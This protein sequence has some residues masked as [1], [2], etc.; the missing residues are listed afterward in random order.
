MDRDVFI[1]LA[2]EIRPYLQPGRSP[3]GLDVLSVEKQLALTLYFLEDQGSLSMTANAF[4]IAR[5]TVSVIVRKV[6]DVI[7]KVLG[8]K[9]IKLQSTE[10]QMKDIM[11]GMEDKYGFQ[12]GTHIAI[13]QPTENPHDYFSYKQ[14][15]TLNVQA[16]CDWRGLFIDVEVKW[17]G[18]VHDGR[19]FANFRVNRLLKEEKIPIFFK[20]LLSGYDKVPVT[21]LGDPA[22]P[23]LPYCMKEYPHART[24]EEVIFNN[25]LRSARNPI[26]CAFGRLKARWQILNKRIDMGLVFVPSVVYA[27]FVLHNFCE[28]QNMTTEDDAVAR[29]VACDRLSPA[30][31]KPGKWTTRYVLENIKY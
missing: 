24:N 21:L 7:A 19:D 1:A 18:S 27:C 23:L 5:C 20:E 8:P 2:D 17:P 10:Q 12:Y 15:Y 6:C 4:G 16:A 22:Y 26:E 25:M 28:M 11:K 14:K 3:R 31:N 9:Y 30:L 29:Q 13:N